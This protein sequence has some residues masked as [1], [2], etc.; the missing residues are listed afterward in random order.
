MRLVVTGLN[1][2]GES[3]VIESRDLGAGERDTVLGLFRT[4]TSQPPR[5]AGHG[6]SVDNGV[7]PGS[8]LWNLVTWPPGAST[9]FHHTDSF[10]FDIILEGSVELELDDGRHS[11]SQGDCIIVAGVDHAWHVG[12]RGCTLTALNMGTP[13]PHA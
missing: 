11:L 12:L 7:A 4:T 5:P 9:P 6:D 10:D 13:P 1:S 2:K 8:L 3:A